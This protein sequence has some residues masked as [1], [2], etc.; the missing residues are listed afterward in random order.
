[1]EQEGNKYRVIA[2]VKDG[3]LVSS[4][5][6]CCSGKNLGRSNET[7][8]ETQAELEILAKYK[9]QKAQG[10]YFEA[11]A[12]IDSFTF[13]NPMLCKKW[14]DYG[15]DISFPL[16][17]QPKL[18]GQRCIV[19]SVGMFSRLGKPVISCPHI[20]TELE[21]VLKDE[22]V[23]FDGELYSSRF[24]QD[25]N[26][27]VSL[28]KK[29][30]PTPEDLV[31]SA[32]YIEYWVYDIV[33]T[34]LSF[35]E[36]FIKL[37]SILRT[38]SRSIIKIVQTTT[39][40]NQQELDSIYAQYL[41]DGYEGQIIRVP[42]AVYQSKRTKDILKRK[43]FLDDE[44][45]IVGVTE[46]VGNRGGML[47]YFTLKTK[48]GDIFDAN[49]RGNREYYREILNNKDKIIGSKATVRFQNYTP[50][51]TPVPRFPVVVS[52]RDYE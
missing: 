6:T 5:W 27:I 18:D 49:A 21:P 30:K 1:M 7:S 52:V 3:N 10:G 12:F 11:E 25:F 50:G 9:K 42:G 24:S 17:S 16:M 15:S 2:G 8:P 20:F 45:E 48:K 26:A 19:S 22:G 23:I 43:E 4:E 47:G 37:S 46:G 32:K 41:Q 39:V 34:N 14:D 40:Y 51:D 28:T 31:E 38:T 29:T 36:R 33:D 13:V 44:F 35:K